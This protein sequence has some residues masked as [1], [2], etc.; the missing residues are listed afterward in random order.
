MLCQQGHKI[1]SRW[2]IVGPS[3]PDHLTRRCCYVNIPHWHH[4]AASSS[5]QPG[6][7]HSPGPM[8]ASVWRVTH[9]CTPYLTCHDPKRHEQKVLQQPCPTSCQLGAALLVL[10]LQYK[11]C[12]WYY[13]SVQGSLAVAGR[14]QQESTVCTCLL[15]IKVIG[16]YHPTRPV[17]PSLLFRPAGGFKAHSVCLAPLSF[18]WAASSPPKLFPSPHHTPH[19]HLHTHSPTGTTTLLLYLAYAHA[20][21][22]QY[23]VSSTFGFWLVH[24]AA[25]L[26]RG[27]ILA[28]FL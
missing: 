27:V 10:L 11:Y 15:L 25:L 21:L 19:T 2:L 7:K 4:C 22:P 1:G 24:F 20:V 14:P 12:Y 23:I 17:E 5:Q 13:Y 26:R 9:L 6:S 18:A 16:Y 8:Q 28:C 3:P